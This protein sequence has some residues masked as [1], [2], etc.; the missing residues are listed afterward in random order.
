MLFLEKLIQGVELYFVQFL[1][2]IWEAY[3]IAV[4]FN[5]KPV[6]ADFANKPIKQLKKSVICKMLHKSSQNALIFTGYVTWLLEN[7][8]RIL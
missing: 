4:T 2:I 7:W 6:L 5:V 1:I 3:K 8:I